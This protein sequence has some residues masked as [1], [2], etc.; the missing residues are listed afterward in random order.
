MAKIRPFICVRPVKEVASKIAALPYDVYSLSEAREVVAKEPLSFLKI[1]RAETFF[2]DDVDPYDE[3]VYEKA[4]ELFCEY[5]NDGHMIKDEEASYYIYQLEMNHRT[6]TGIVACAAVDDYVNHVIKT[7]EN[8]RSEKEQDRIRHVEVLNAQT[9][10]IFLAYRSNALINQ[11]VENTCQ[12]EPLYNFIAD[13]G[14][15][16]TVWKVGNQEDTNAIS[17]E[18]EKNEAIYI[19][20]GHHRAAAA[21]KVGQKRKQLGKEQE[22]DYFLSVLFPDDQLMIMPYNRCVTDLNGLTKEQF[23]FLVKE[24]FD[25]ILKGTVAY[26]PE[27]KGK[28]GMYLDDEWYQLSLKSEIAVD[29]DPVSQL[30]VS[31]LHNNLIEPILGITQ[32]KTDKRIDFVGG[33][34][35]LSELEKRVHE[36]MKVAFS[37]YA[38][39]IH[40]VFEVS[41]HGQLMPPKSTWFEPK[42]RSGLFIH[43][44]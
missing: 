41:D 43:E 7:H 33:I 44:L 35:G 38:T 12:N 3:R 23:L 14:V 4:A 11:A 22:S 25:V 18:F 29:D 37:M 1:D 28:F 17:G 16:H 36:D 21:V 42:L 40:E 26:A 15:R 30:D 8:T 39:D 20:D 6:Q 13:D 19:A 24:K 34:R 9:G 27:S 31:I 10:P 32:P 2:D 5:K